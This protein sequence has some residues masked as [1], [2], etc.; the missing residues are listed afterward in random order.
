MKA[1]DLKVWM[2]ENEKS[3]IDVASATKTSPSTVL[4]FLAGERVHRSTQAA[5]E[6]LVN[7]SRAQGEGPP[8]AR[9]A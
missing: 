4:R 2:E 1:A 9:E 3:T 5:F 6:R 7:D 8:R